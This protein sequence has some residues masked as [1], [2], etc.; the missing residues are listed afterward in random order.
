MTPE[1]REIEAS[2]VSMV[3]IEAVHDFC[4]K[5]GTDDPMPEFEHSLMTSEHAY[6]AG[7]LFA[8]NAIAH[9]LM[10]GINK[11]GELAADLAA[12]KIDV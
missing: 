11:A 8:A 12:G 2:L 10:S 6:Y 7:K 5:Y 3:L 1:H 9:S 4:E